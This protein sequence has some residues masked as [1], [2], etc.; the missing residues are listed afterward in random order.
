M[1]RCQ[2]VLESADMSDVLISV[3]DVILYIT[4][5]YPHVFPSYFRVSLL[6]TRFVYGK[7][8]G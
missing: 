3:V 5:Y 1:E 4:K 7:A 2:E 6:I 8:S